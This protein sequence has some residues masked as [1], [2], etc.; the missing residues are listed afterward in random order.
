[1]ISPRTA[2]GLAVAALALLGFACTGQVSDGSENGGSGTSSDP[3]KPG[4]GRGNG[5]G[6]NPTGGGPPPEIAPGPD[7]V[8]DAAGPYTLRRLTVLE[9]SNTLRDLLGV[10]LSEEERRALG[11]DQV[12]EGG[13]RRGSA[14]VTT[15]DSRLLLDTSTKVAGT[16]AADMDRLMPAGCGAPT[17]AAEQ[18]CIGKF[19]EE[20]G[21]RAFRRPVS[22]EE[23]AAFMDLYGKLRGADV[24]TSFQEAVHDIL[25]AVLQSPEF[26]YRWELDGEPIKDG[27]LIKFGPYEVASRL[28]YFLWASMP[29]ED[30]F[31]AAKAGELITPEQIGAQ[32]ERMMKDERAKDAL[33]DFHMQWLG[34]YGVDE[35]EKG[36]I[37]MNY[38]PEVIGRAMMAETAAFVDATLF[39]DGASGM[40]SDLFTSSRSF[41]NGP[42]AE[43]YGLSGVSGDALA[44]VEHDST[45][46]AGILTLGAF[47]TKH[48]KEVESF[49]I[50]RGVYVLRNVLCQ[51]IPEPQIELPP[52]PEQTM[53]VTTRKLYEDFTAAPACKACHGAINAVGFAFENYDAVGGFRSMEEGQP[54]DS[55]GSLDLPSG[56]LTWQNGIEFVHAVAKS[57][58]LSECVARSW[59]RYLLRRQE[60]E[61]EAGSL[62]AIRE[63]FASADFDMRALIVGL[64]KTRAFTHYNPASK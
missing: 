30:L 46:R 13:F 39:G 54:V 16:A 62:K 48:S 17:A 5:S 34:I 18:E 14:V 58:E 45:K 1:M 20:F 60:H 50:D 9:Y 15:V 27:D 35:I 33:R 59:M 2:P 37:Y 31:A 24:G 42:L 38:T 44:G 32:A 36:D 7:G 11:V 41:V 22:S 26:L 12:L 57:P 6:P 53:G 51:E 25:V 55:S 61:H 10:A 8:V 40:L 29:D 28:S 56:K 23:T 43:H 63:A 21:L 19:I 4:S 3:S 52:P 49:P 47:L 64:T